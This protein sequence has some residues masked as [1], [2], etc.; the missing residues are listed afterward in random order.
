[1]TGLQEEGHKDKHTDFKAEIIEVEEKT[2]G[3]DTSKGKTTSI[4]KNDS[5][6]VAGHALLHLL[7]TGT[8]AIPSLT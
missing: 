2:K 5:N 7:H 3:K 4:A 1:M 8:R 6:N